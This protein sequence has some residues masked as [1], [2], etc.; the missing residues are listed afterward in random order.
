VRP[1]QP[2]LTLLTR[3]SK[4]LPVTDFE[5]IIA[6][7]DQ[8]VGQRVQIHV[9]GGTGITL[10]ALVGMLRPVEPD[11]VARTFG[12]SGGPE[13]AFY[14]VDGGQEQ[15]QFPLLAVPYAAQQ[16]EGGNVMFTANGAG[17]MV[18]TQVA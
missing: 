12:N 2:G 16:I 4:I 17:V 10:V 14:Y 3:R 7:L 18:S 15:G 13:C 5:Q 1:G 9:G 11:F 8:L 6:E